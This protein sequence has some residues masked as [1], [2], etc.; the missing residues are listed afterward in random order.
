MP[1]RAL[2]LKT[3]LISK[4]EW[5]RRLGRSTP[6]HGDTLGVHPH[7]GGAA[8]DEEIRAALLTA[9]RINHAAF[10]MSEEEAI[11]EG[12]SLMGYRGVTAKANHKVGAA[13]KKLVQDGAVTV[14]NYKISV[15]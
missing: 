13:L 7:A 9:K 15:A 11:S 4:S 8:P 10:S 12:L 14:E 1:L 3:D 5:T 6:P 2:N